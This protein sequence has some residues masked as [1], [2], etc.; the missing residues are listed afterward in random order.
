VLGVSE[1][2][3]VLPIVFVNVGEVLKLSQALQRVVDLGFDS[4]NFSLD[5]KI[6]VHAFNGD[7]NNN[8]EFDSIIHHCR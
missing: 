7:N 1:N 3:L 6:V 8:N 2:N 5:S 4:T